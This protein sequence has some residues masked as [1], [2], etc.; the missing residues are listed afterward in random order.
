MSNIVITGAS[1]GIGMASALVLARAGHSVVATMRNPGASPEL[2][3]IARKENLRV[4]V[5]QLDV[6]SDSSVKDCFSRIYS[7]GT[8]DV[9]VNNA[10]IEKG[11]SVEETPLEDFRICMETNYFG[12][13]RCTQAVAKAMREQRKGLIVNVTSVGGK[14]SLSPLSPYAASKFALE[15]VSESLAQEMRLFGVRVAIVEPGIIDTRMARNINA[16]PNS[17]VYPQ[18]KRI[19]AMF[20]AALDAG[21]G[22]PEI[23][24]EKILEIIE[25]GTTQLRHP[26]GP[27]AVPFLAWRAA[28]TDDQWTEWNSMPEADWIAA[29][30]RDFGM[31]IKL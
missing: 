16:F 8:I 25:S 14:I 7:H 12:A 22:R 26:A 13:I 17:P 20:K 24:G 21:A 30:K 1:R 19:A 18:A 6:D 27:D 5:E 31:E 4:T 15:A 23:V 11:G 3:D 10:G 28:M 29:V 2:A 9:L